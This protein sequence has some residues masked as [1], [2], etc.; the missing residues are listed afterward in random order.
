[1][2]FNKLFR[3]V[4]AAVSAGLVLVFEQLFFPDKANG[5][6][7]MDNVTMIKELVS[8]NMGIS[9]IAHSICREEEQQGKLA[10][11]PIENSNMIRQINMVHHP[12][13]SHQE[14]LDDLR[15]IYRRLNR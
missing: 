1:M 7:E 15:H 14:V 9:I 4:F 5:I 12:D 6:I 10:V 8:L 2:R 11:V 13:F 3:K